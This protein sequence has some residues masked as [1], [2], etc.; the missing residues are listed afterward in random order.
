VIKLKLVYFDARFDNQDVI[1]VVLELAQGGELFDF[2]THAG[3]FDEMTARTY[4]RQLIDGVQFAHNQGVVHRDLKPENLLLDQIFVLKLADFGFAKIFS[5]VAQARTMFT[6]CGTPGYMAPE[7]S[8]GKGY[9]PVTTDIW[10]CGVIL[11]I[12]IAGFP[13]FQSTTMS[14]WWFAKLVANKHHLFWAAHCRTATFSEP[15]KDLINRILAPDSSKRLSLAEI[16]KHPWFDGPVIAD[17]ALFTEMSRRKNVVDT[18]KERKRAQE[19]L[20]AQ[21]NLPLADTPLTSDHVMRDIETVPD[22]P[23]YPPNMLVFDKPAK[24][25]QSTML[26]TDVGGGFGLFG[27]AAEVVMKA[28]VYDATVLSAVYTRFESAQPVSSVFDRIA[29]CFQ[30]MK[31]QHSKD[32]AACS[33]SAS[34]VTSAGM[35]SFA[36]QLFAAT[37]ATDCATIVE[38]RRRKGDSSQF[39]HIFYEVR[40]QIKDLISTPTPTATPA[41]AAPAVSASAA[42]AASASASASTATPA[43]PPPANAGSVPAVASASAASAAASK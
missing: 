37:T 43:P 25:L 3:S 22:M 14:D 7:M 34:M 23:L 9:D 32:K 33:L 21:A 19:R 36:V 1:L 20:Q 31:I 35:V 27:A 12:M 13:P 38:F 41:A 24:T 18:S 4:F 42:S 16:R 15:A 39:R 40:E 2:L 26:L 8:T 17:A 5:P 28:P 6:E 29:A 30:E 11:F 10:A